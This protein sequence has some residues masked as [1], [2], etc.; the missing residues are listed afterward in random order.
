MSKAVEWSDQCHEIW[1]EAHE[2]ALATDTAGVLG[3][4]LLLIVALQM[5]N[6]NLDSSK[7]VT[8]INRRLRD[9]DSPIY[10]LVVQTKNI[11]TDNNAFFPKYDAVEKT[12]KYDAVPHLLFVQ[13]ENSATNQQAID[14]EWSAQDEEHTQALSECGFF[15]E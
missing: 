7:I 6:D 9:N 11:S 14:K 8:H 3:N 12:V 1:L 10:L 5:C 4:L 2:R 13:L 15:I